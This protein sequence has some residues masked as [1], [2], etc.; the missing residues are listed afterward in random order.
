MFYKCVNRVVW[1]CWFFSIFWIGTGIWLKNV[2]LLGWRCCSGLQTNRRYIPDKVVP[3]PC[4]I[5]NRWLLIESEMFKYIM[6]LLGV[7]LFRGISRSAVYSGSYLH[8]CCVSCWRFHEKLLSSQKYTHN[9]T[10]MPFHTA[11]GSHW[12]VGTTHLLQV[13]WLHIHGENVLFC[14]FSKVFYLD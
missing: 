1:H 6:V 5:R 12:H 11:F 2:D 13:C 4:Y 8:Q 3:R 10:Q 9:Y 14:H 7:Q